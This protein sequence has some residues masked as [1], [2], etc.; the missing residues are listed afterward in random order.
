MLLQKL[1]SAE[2]AQKPLPQWYRTSNR[3]ATNAGRTLDALHRQIASTP[4]STKRAM[5][6]KARLLAVVHGVALE[7]PLRGGDRSDL[8]AT[9][10][11]SLIA[12]LARRP[13]HRG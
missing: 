13:G 4:A 1:Q 7:S 2:T 12:D 6:M 10:L 8:G 11:R 3:I 9:L 5:W